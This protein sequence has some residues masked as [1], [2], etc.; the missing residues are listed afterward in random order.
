MHGPHA[1]HISR[2]AALPEPV[3]AMKLRHVLNYLLAILFAYGAVLI[4]PML[5]DYVF[6]THIKIVVITWLNIGI[7]V[8]LMKHMTLPAIDMRR[9][10]VKACLTILWWALFWP[11][12][13]IN[14][15]GG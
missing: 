15:L 3:R 10:D 12:Y 5:C 7:V 13:L 11:R 2:C 6:D 1:C 8:M 14:T 4:L 9:I